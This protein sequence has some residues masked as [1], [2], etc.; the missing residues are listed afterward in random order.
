MSPQDRDY[1][2]MLERSVEIDQRGGTVLFRGAVVVLLVAFAMAWARA[3]VH[4]DWVPRVL[5]ANGDAR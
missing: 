4:G 3:Q 5:S 2:A 1:L